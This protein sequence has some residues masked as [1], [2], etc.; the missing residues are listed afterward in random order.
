MPIYE[1]RCR[2]CGHQ[3]EELV[4]PGQQ[5]VCPACGADQNRLEKLISVPAAHTTRLP[6]AG[7][8]APPDAPPCG[9]GCCRLER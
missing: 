1:Y 6:I 3:F 2:H 9:P 7:G 8:C 5:V 4:R